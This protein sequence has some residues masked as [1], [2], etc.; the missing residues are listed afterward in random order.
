[1]SL[2]QNR[3]SDDRNLWGKKGFAREE[4]VRRKKKKKGCASQSG[5]IQGSLDKDSAIRKRESWRHGT[6]NTPSSE[7]VEH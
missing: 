7:G 5:S 3:A 4:R 1:M 6:R 2:A